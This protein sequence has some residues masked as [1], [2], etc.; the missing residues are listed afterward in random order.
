MANNCANNNATRLIGT[1]NF[2]S[3][4]VLTNGIVQLGNVYRRFC[5]KINGVKTFEFDNTDVVLQQTGIYHITVTAVGSG[6]EAGTL[7]IQLYENGFAVPGVFA[8]ET[9]TTPDTE[10]RTL[11]LDYF[12]LVDNTCVLGCNSTVAKA[13]SIVNTGVEATYTSVVMNVEKVV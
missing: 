8:N 3:Q 2:A 5:R 12:V 9:I 1:R 11:T 6:A 10:L 13:I 4:E 7:A